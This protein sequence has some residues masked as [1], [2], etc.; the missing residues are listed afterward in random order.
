MRISHL[1]L[2]DFRNYSRLDLSLPAGRLLFLGDNAQGKTNL[3]EAV[4]LL[5]TMRSLRV[6]TD[7]EL[8][9]WEALDGPIPVARL[10][11][12]AETSSGPVRVEMIIEGQQTAS[13]TDDRAR[14]AKKV[15]VNGTPR[16]LSGAMGRIKAV[17]FTSPDID[18]VGGPPAL[19]RRYLD[20]ALSQVDEAY[21][22]ALQQYGKVL[23]QRNA[24]LHRVQSALAGRD[25]LAFW[26]VRFADLAAAIVSRRARAV[27]L[28]SG[29]AGETHAFLS[30]AREELMVAYRP[31]GGREWDGADLSDA[32]ERD[33]AAGLVETL[34]RNRERE[35]AAAASLWGPHRDDVA[36]TLN[37]RPA[38]AFASRAQ[39]RTIALALRLAEA[40]LLLERSGEHP[41]LLLDDIL[42][43]MDARRRTSVLEA[44]GGFDQVWITSAEQ[45]EIERIAVGATVFVVED[46]RV[47]RL[48]QAFRGAPAGTADS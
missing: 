14:A 29:Y 20:V 6:S 3:L 26:D 23:T 35:V 36:L 21:L 28:L 40:R 7:V 11:A 37:G 31:R 43:E 27:A 32:E 19:R 10:V 13:A 45:G 1:S 42:S 25:E 47:R 2:S 44:A 15:R 16:R 18:L 33:I 41:V 12:D 38:V 48:E 30:D 46:G 24:L 17:L 5:S 22:G 4:H 34:N 8:I 9:R 39:A